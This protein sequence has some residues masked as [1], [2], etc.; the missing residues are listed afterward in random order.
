M[1]SGK[2]RGE[3]IYR[4]ILIATGFRGRHEKKSPLRQIFQYNGPDP[5]NRRPAVKAGNARVLG[6]T[7]WKII[8]LKLV[9]VMVI[10]KI[11]LCEARP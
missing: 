9:I 1:V 4:L 6:R 11:F 8:L 3:I 7:P 2:F 5:A 10:I